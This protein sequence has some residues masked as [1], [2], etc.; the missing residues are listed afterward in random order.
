M[1]RI[2]TIKP[3]FWTDSRIVQLPFEARL[4]FI[5]LWNFADDEGY[6]PYDAEQIKLQI[7]P[8]DDVDCRLLIDTL[9]AAELLDVHE[10]RN[11]NDLLFVRHFCD[12]QK[13]SHP[14]KSK[15][16]P[17]SSGRKQSIPTH[18]RRALAMKYG[19]KPGEVTDC[20]CYYCGAPGKIHWQK[21]SN[22]RPGAWVSFSLSIDH[23]EAESQGGCTQADN[24][25]LAC[26]ECNKS[27]GTR[28][29]FEHVLQSPLEPSRVL[30]LEGN[31]KEGN[32]KE[33]KGEGEVRASARFVPPSVEE[34]REYAQEAGLSI[35][36]QAFVDFYSSKGWKVG[37]S[38]MK[39]WRASARNA[40]RGG[41]CAKNG[42]KA[43]PLAKY[44][45]QGGRNAD[46]R[47]V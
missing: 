22:G 16:A 10:A 8:A 43:D 33:L 11:G 15:L 30:A 26:I 5:G 12:H 9:V 19:C 27:K 28:T 36:A 6:L 25:V 20:Q 41:W 3:E 31:G 44:L 40:D 13:I 21:L 38:A 2:R 45:H 39:D 46:T 34:V 42:A 1:A 47:T 14:A 24:F 7:L 23:L 35:D 37:K 18:S 29:V 32:G 4:L 17:E